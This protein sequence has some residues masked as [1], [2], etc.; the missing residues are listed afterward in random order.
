ML[1][2]ALPELPRHA[3]RHDADERIASAIN[4]VRAILAADLVPAHKRELL[5]VCIWKLTLA[6]PVNKYATRFVSVA[7][8]ACASRDRV[9]EHVFERSRLVRALIDGRLPLDELPASAVACV[10]TRDEHARLARAAVEKPGIE[11]WDRYRAASIAV[12]D[13]ARRCWQLEP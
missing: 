12:V 13:C 4:A 1:Q 10:V 9:H 11:G 3:R 6:E 2:I 8:V 7:A 5:S